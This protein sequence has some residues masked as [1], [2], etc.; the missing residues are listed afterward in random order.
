[1][2]RRRQGGINEGVEG[3][4]GIG[5]RFGGGFSKFLDD[6]YPR[7]DPPGTRP[8]ET[9]AEAAEGPVEEVEHF[10]RGVGKCES[11]RVTFKW[12]YLYGIGVSAEINNKPQF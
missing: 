1:M 5:V 3:I 11:C 12:A 8:S 2:N 4:V 7:S 6:D 9:G 10:R